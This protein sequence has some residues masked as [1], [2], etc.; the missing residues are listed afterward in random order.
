GDDPVDAAKQ[1]KEQLGRVPGRG[2]G[3]GLL[4][5]LNPQTAP[6]LTH[7]ARPQIGFN[8]LGRTVASSAS[9]SGDWT[10]ADDAHA[11]GAGTDPATPLL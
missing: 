8:Y 9:G 2:F 3:H 11:L 6:L 4:R 10:V 1:V 5:Y 7:C